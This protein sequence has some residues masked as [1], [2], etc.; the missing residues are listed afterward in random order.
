MFCLHKRIL[1]H[2]FGFFWKKTHTWRAGWLRKS[3]MPVLYFV[4]SYEINRI[5]P[6][7]VQFVQLIERRPSKTHGFH[8]S[9]SKCAYSMYCVCT[10]QCGFFGL[11]IMSSALQCCAKILMSNAVVIVGGPQMMYA[12]TR[13]GCSPSECLTTYVVILR[14]YPT[15][16]E[17]KM[18]AASL[19]PDHLPP[20][21]E[22][23]ALGIA[24][25]HDISP[26]P[27]LQKI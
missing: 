25:I 19:P 10:L 6:C 26:A 12:S 11:T 9:W 1:H 18:S 8:I 24:S 23:R 15:V 2:F 27:R 16:K 21:H 5:V 13:H 17:I 20:V 7:T 14:S 3:R 22:R 4:P